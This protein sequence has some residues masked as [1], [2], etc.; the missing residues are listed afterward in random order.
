LLVSMRYRLIGR[1]AAASK[2][3]RLDGATTVIVDDDATRNL[4]LTLESRA[5]GARN[6]SGD[7]GHL[8]W[9]IAD[10]DYLLSSEQRIESEFVQAKATPTTH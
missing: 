2:H 9:R 10:I 5:V 4:M 6:E 3:D 8:E 7:G 1:H